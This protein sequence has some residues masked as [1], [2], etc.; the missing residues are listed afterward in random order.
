M[1]PPTA[2]RWGCEVRGGSDDVVRLLWE[3]TVAAEGFSG[4]VNGSSASGV[5]GVGD[6]N[7]NYEVG[8][9]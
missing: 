9:D 1:H 3:G 5:A 6:T 8:V 4:N 2:G 7:G